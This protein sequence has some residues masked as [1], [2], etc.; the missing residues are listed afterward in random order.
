MNR[1]FIWL[2]FAFGFAACSS[3]SSDD[4]DIGDASTNDAGTSDATIAN[5]AGADIDAGTPAP[6]VGEALEG[7][8]LFDGWEDPR[9]LAAPVNT[10]GW[11]DS[12]YISASGRTLYFGYA[13][14]DYYQL[15]IGNAVI[16]GPV[17]PGGTRDGF[18]IYE[19]TIADGGWNVLRSTVNSSDTSISE[20]AEGVDDAEQTMAYVKFFGGNADDVYLSKKSGGVWGAGVALPYPINT[21]CIEDNAALSRD[22]NTLYFD[23]NRIDASDGGNCKST[24]DITS[25]TIYRS[26]FDGTNWS[27]PVALGGAPN[28]G[29]FHWQVYPREDPTMYWAGHDTGCGGDACIMR[30]QLESDGGYGD[31]VVVMQATPSATAVVGQVYAIGEV[32]ITRDGHWMYFTYIVK[33]TAADGGVDASIDVGVAHH[34]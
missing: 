11:E 14:Y 32:S 8:T 19:A 17:R 3:S 2:L 28:G 27:D 1:R 34:P 24:N 6:P 26:Q 5:D 23:S 21:S 30:A 15:S 12:T 16:D 31:P 25:R 4:S 10:S 29:L 33:T 18:E 13:R 20:A 22:G 9:A 7:L